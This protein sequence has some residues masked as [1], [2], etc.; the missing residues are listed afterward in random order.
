M[1]QAIRDHKKLILTL[2]SGALLL[3]LAVVY[4][5]PFFHMF[6]TSLKTF[7][8]AN[9]MPP[10]LLPEEPQFQNYAEAWDSM[11]VLHYLKNSVIITGCTIIGQMFVCVPAAYAFAKKQFRLKKVLMPALL[12]DLL[13]PAQIVFLPIYVIVSN[14]GLLNTYRSLVL[15]FLYSAFTIFFLTQSF[16][17]IPDELLDAGRMDHASEWQIITRILIPSARSV[18]ITVA[19]FTFV[20]KWNDYFWAKVLTTDETVRTLPM[21]VSGLLSVGDGMIHWN[22]VMAG[23]VFLFAPMLIIYLLAN[24]SIK[25]AFTYGGIK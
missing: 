2:L 23:N 1:T 21:A 8:E 12:F 4:I 22:V 3:I 19:L 17:T 9:M 5:F 13:V 25:Q 14:A 20:G 10:K 18:I 16:R 6:S 15:P 11:N 24:R 7:A